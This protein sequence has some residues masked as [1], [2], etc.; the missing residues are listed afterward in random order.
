VLTPVCR[1]APP[2]SR[3]WAH[4]ACRASLRRLSAHA[5]AARQ[6]RNAT[7]TAVVHRVGVLRLRAWGVLAGRLGPCVHA[8]AHRRW[9]LLQRGFDAW[10]LV[11]LALWCQREEARR[12]EA[13]LHAEAQLQQQRMEQEAAEQRRRQEAEE[14]ERRRQQRQLE[15]EAVEQRRRQQAEEDEE[16]R[17]RQ[18]AAAVTAAAERVAVER[19]AAAERAQKVAAAEQAALAE[20]VALAVRKAAA[21]EQAATAA[22]AR[23]AA[24][25]ATVEEAARVLQNERDAHLQH[26]LAR[27]RA[28][29]LDGLRAAEAMARQHMDAL[30]AARAEAAAAVAH[31][32]RAV[33]LAV[34]AA[35][36][37]SGG[38]RWVQGKGVSSVQKGVYFV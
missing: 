17:Q 2:S 8:A 27:A 35:H 6:Q 34:A 1:G 19:A 32:V 33:G 30:V 38:A 16:R 26:A 36:L 15:Q 13:R 37:G 23:A 24:A 5:S 20:V 21:A 7:A 31:L 11:V 4:A 14:D 10:R 29:E 28:Q 22:E 12:Q 9:A 3:R 18:E 25:Q